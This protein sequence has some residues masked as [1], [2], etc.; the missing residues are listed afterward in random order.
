MT[1]DSTSRSR[2]FDPLVRSE[3]EISSYILPLM[4][5]FNILGHFNID[6]A[7][8]L[9]FI[10]DIRTAYS[11]IINPFHN[12]HHGFDVFHTSYLFLKQDESTGSVE[13]SGGSASLQLDP[14]SIFSCLLA[15]LCHDVA[16]TGRN[17]S[18]EINSQSPLALL[19]NDDAVLERH[20]CHTTMSILN[21]SKNIKILENFGADEKR[22][23]RKYV[24]TAIL[25]TDMATH[26]KLVEDCEKR[27][28]D[29]AN[30]FDI[31]N[32]D[33]RLFMVKS[34]VHCADLGGQT[35][36]WE[37]ANK[38]G[39][40]VIKEFMSQSAME[41]NLGIPESPFMLG[42]EDEMLK[43][44]LQTGFITYV[45]LPLWDAMTKI[46][47]GMAPH[48]ISLKDNRTKY[49][50]IVDNLQKEKDEKEKLDIVE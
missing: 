18:F 6:K 42:L 12:F 13:Y 26:F 31:N 27:L 46:F 41:K 10:N 32:A 24:I 25:A 17:N 1:F 2:I 23:F 35:A 50:E 47:P 3:I 15:A 7:S 9:S 29:E 16:H 37:L 48:L 43:N 30:F 5:E 19:H 21:T 11:T 20:H 28:L 39:S 4:N 38:W 22:Q 40:L 8:L 14:L 44:R 36:P 34:I 49:T 33:D 45:L